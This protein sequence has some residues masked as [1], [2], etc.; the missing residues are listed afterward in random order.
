MNIIHIILVKEYLYNSYF[1]NNEVRSARTFGE[2]LKLPEQGDDLELCHIHQPLV[3]D[4][5]LRDYW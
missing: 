3:G 4:L 1:V 5:E 2:A